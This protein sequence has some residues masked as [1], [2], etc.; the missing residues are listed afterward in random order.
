M[1]AALIFLYIVVVL[2][3][4]LLCLVVK[5]RLNTIEREV[6]AGGYDPDLDGLATS[7]DFNRLDDRLKTMGLQ[8]A[9]FVPV[10]RFETV[11]DTV[12]RQGQSLAALKSV[13]DQET[14]FVVELGEKVDLLSKGIQSV[15]DMPPAVLPLDFA[16]LKAAFMDLCDRVDDLEALP[17]P[18]PCGE[19]AN[20]LRFIADRIDPEPHA[21][22]LFDPEPLPGP[23]VDGPNFDDDEEDTPDLGETIPPHGLVG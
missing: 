21:A 6:R 17:A 14:A 23:A 8:L 22:P 16:T 7:A 4:A 19:A 20:F 3:G 5:R 9:K 10:S 18:D 1:H 13:A 15:A 12:S 2:G 11:A